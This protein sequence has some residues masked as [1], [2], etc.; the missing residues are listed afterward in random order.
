MLCHAVTI[1][2]KQFAKRRTAEGHQVVLVEGQFFTSRGIREGSSQRGRLGLGSARTSAS[3][4]DRK[5][6]FTID[7]L[8]RLNGIDRR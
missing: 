6:S 4:T 3:A 7:P 1:G 5:A 8:D 2:R